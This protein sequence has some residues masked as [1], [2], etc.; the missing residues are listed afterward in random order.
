[1]DGWGPSHQ[2]RPPPRLRRPWPHRML[3][4]V[5]GVY[6]LLA[7]IKAGSG[8]PGPTPLVWAWHWLGAGLLALACL[9]VARRVVP[10][11]YRLAHSH[12]RQRVRVP[13]VVQR[14]ADPLVAVREHA[15]V[16]GGGAF[17]GLR[18]GGAWAVAD[19]EQ[20]VMI[21]GPPR[22]GKTSCI[23]IPALLAAPGPA[24]STSTKA[25]VLHATR[26]ARGRLGT[27]WVYD[28]AG[29]MSELPSGVRRL[30]WSPVGAAGDWDG[31]LLMA[32]AMTASSQV[33]RGTTHQD[34]WAERAGAL[35]A[36]L[37]LAARLAGR[38]V[39][40]VARWVLRQDINTPSL[41]LEEHGEAVASDVLI[42]IAQ[43]DSRERSSIFSA[44]AGVLAAYRSDA[45]RRSA[46]RA[47]FDAARFVASQDTVFVCAPAH[48]QALCAPLVVGLLEEIR[49][50]TYARH[51]SGQADPRRPVFFALDEVANIAPMNDLPALVSEAGGQGLHVLVCLQD[52]SQ[53]R[54]R[55]G[56]HAADGFLSLFQTRLVLRG[57]G[58]SRTLEAI[59]LG[60]G[61][62]D[63]SL[64]HTAISASASP[65]WF[66]GPGSESTSVS[67]QTVRQRT[68]S[69]G[70]VAQI[71]RGRGLLLS[72]DGWGLLRLAPWYATAPWRDV[73]CAQ[74]FADP[75]ALAPPR[76]VLSAV[77]EPVDPPN[78]RPS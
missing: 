75:V 55:W 46:A 15:A 76:A 20:S 44:T 59:S 24:V 34:H 48:K 57:I 78:R 51:A 28:P 32:R 10:R 41:I 31:A 77:P 65:G 27:V 61:E 12:R 45:A 25:E 39:G 52:L 68:L 13:T 30:C 62:Y 72:A 4:R 74:S 19:G 22:S 60:L 5:L 66:T 18:P 3:G 64:A 7:V 42:G 49:H 26:A 2:H 40:D 37:L 47:N 11:I 69:P 16:L 54:S 29:A 21:L 9:P 1:M 33:G 67:Y 23:V 70:E 36:P 35:L 63:R 17:L 50:A 38:G 43:T 73:A 56:D 8:L 71:P 53:V 6:L 58:D 14:A